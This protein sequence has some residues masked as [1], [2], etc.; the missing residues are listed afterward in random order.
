MG[1]SDVCQKQKINWRAIETTVEENAYSRLDWQA[2]VEEISRTNAYAARIVT[3][4]Q[5]YVAG[6]T[7]S[8]NLSPD[9]Y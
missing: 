2:N 4:Y 6:T 9:W 8:L 5:S 7:F 1:D 3:A